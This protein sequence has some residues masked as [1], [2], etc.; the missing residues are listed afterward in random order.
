MKMQRSTNL[1]LSVGHA[2]S[3]LAVRLIM[4]PGLFD[5]EENMCSMTISTDSLLNIE[6][7]GQSAL[8]DMS[9]M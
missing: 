4:K 2:A 8:K 3:F 1:C 5:I 6:D 7:Y 9:K